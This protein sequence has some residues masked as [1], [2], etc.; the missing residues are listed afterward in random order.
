MNLK[1]FA[2]KIVSPNAFIKASFGGFAGSGKTR[3]AT[4]FIIG[5]YRQLKLTKPILIIDNEKGS[6][7][8]VPIFKEAGI[9]TYIKDTTHLADVI[10]SFPLVENREVDF[11]FIDSLSK[12]WYQFIRDYRKNH[13][14]RP[15]TLQDWGKVIPEWQEKFSD[16]F[17]NLN[18]S[19]VFTGRGGFTYDMEE[20]ENGKKAFVKS[21][22]KM[23]VAGETPFE[24]DLNLWM[25][26][27][28][29]IPESG[30]VIQYRTSQVLKDRSA[31]IDG[32]TF[33]N[34][35]YADFK[36]VVD[37][38][39]QLPMG[40]VSGATNTTNLA[41]V[42]DSTYY[43]KKEA[44][45]A[46][47]EKIKSLFDKAGFGTSKEDK[48][49]KAEVTQRI[50]GTLSGTEIEKKSVAEL[51]ESI[52]YLTSILDGLQLLTDQPEKIKYVKDF[53]ISNELK[54]T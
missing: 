6:R 49:L 46:E 19:C 2:Q 25:E 27:C 18:G 3:T 34:P 29:D 11:L 45:E 7:F 41:P 9:E 33:K 8:L 43:A 40:D 51:K 36:P 15:M 54:L 22:V 12:I 1:D 53:P 35:V 17:V 21:G 42:D 50:F 47:I 30:H 24:T 13:N 5:V 16:R 4:E 52:V 39:T 37:F 23:K 28:Q 48:Q 31:T 44:R 38:I 14:N 20:D 10:D 26:L 32:K